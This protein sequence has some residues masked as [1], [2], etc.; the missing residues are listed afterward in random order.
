MAS[1]FQEWQAKF[2]G[3]RDERGMPIQTS[4]ITVLSSPHGR[5]RRNQRNID[6]RDLQTA[7]KYGTVEPGHPCPKTGGNRWK[8]TFAGVVYITDHSGRREITSYPVAGANTLDIKKIDVSSRMQVAH[9]QN[10]KLIKLVPSSWKSHTVVVVDQSGSMKIRDVSNRNEQNST[11]HSNSKS[12]FA[13]E[14]ATRSEAVWITLAI[15]YVAKRLESGEATSMDVFS[16]I[17]MNDDATVLVEELPTDWILFNHL[18]D[19]LRKERPRSHGNYMPALNAA[20][21][22]LLRNTSGSCALLLLFLSDGKPS[23]SIKT[24]KH[25]EGRTGALNSRIGALASRFGRRLTVGTIG[26]SHPNEDFSVLQSMA[27]T[28]ED[29]GSISSFQAP[30]LSTDALGI[31]MSSLTSSLTATKTELTELGHC[32]VQRTVRMVQRESRNTF[33][34]IFFSNENWFWYPKDR[35]NS[36][37]PYKWSTYERTWVPNEL[38]SPLAVGVA[39]RKNVFAEGA[40]RMVRKFRE[41]DADGYFVGPKMVAKEGRFNKDMNYK[42]LKHFHEI[43]CR[44]QIKAQEFA[45]KFNDSLSRIHGVNHTTPRICFLDCSVYVMNDVIRGRIGVLVEKMLDNKKYI[46]W[47]SNGGYVHGQEPVPPNP[48]DLMDLD[49]LHLSIMEEGSDGEEEVQEQEEELGCRRQ[50]KIVIRDAD[51]PQAF[52][53]YTFK[54]TNRKMMVCDLQGVLDKSCTPP[55]FELTDPVIHYR[56]LDRKNV[57]GRTDRGI[58]GMQKFIHS[59]KCSDLCWALDQKWTTR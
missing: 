4:A 8:Y 57:F 29:F 31:A 9:D 33:D 54:K 39:L 27:A 5:Q 28:T 59:H 38:S 45:E 40:E 48:Y 14:D 35:K 42:D 22:L 36:V 50:P 55:L 47:N 10:R 11:P 56:S 53:C 17:G 20:E 25:E 49:L 46:K 1:S 52:T 18:V 15:E 34:D 7:I 6:K 51:I 3:S 32:S 26:F 58:K 12:G 30:S 16:L 19:L 21:N 13:A 2:F 41:V 43:F 23:D 24:R 44:T 37:V